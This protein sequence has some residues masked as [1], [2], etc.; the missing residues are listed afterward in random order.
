MTKNGPHVFV[1]AVV[2]AGSS[3]KADWG[4]VIGLETPEQF[5]PAAG[6]KGDW[7]NSMTMNNSW[8]FIESDDNGNLGNAD[9]ASVDIVSKG[10]NYLLDV[11]PTPGCFAA[12]VERLRAIGE[13]MRVNGES[14]YDTTASPFTRLPWGRCTKRVGPS[15]Q[16]SICTHIRLALQRK[17][18]P[19]AEESDFEKRPV[20]WKAVKTIKR[21]A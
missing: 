16:R 4:A 9:P 15:E 20:R 8:N 11:G 19:R 13:W 21:E 14:I 6:L 5:V 18:R 2:T 12:A 10:G 1:A 7:E 17:L 3:T